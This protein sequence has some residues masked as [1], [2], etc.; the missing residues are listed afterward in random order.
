[1]P[2][3]KSF[4][5]N[6]S[7]I[8]FHQNPQETAYGNEAIGKAIVLLPEYYYQVECLKWPQRIDNKNRLCTSFTFKK[9]QLTIAR[10]MV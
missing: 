5:W 1:M 8:L 4:P 9:A 7:S 6:L 10:H 2:R 3:R